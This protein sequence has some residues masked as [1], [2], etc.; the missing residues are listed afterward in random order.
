[1]LNNCTIYA[2]KSALMALR[3]QFMDPLLLRGEEVG[4]VSSR[5]LG[6]D[7]GRIQGGDSRSTF[8]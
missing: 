8:Q 1:M 5:V 7:R 3:N 6:E 2:R 4:A